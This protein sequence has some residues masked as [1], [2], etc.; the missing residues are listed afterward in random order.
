MN[1]ENFIDVYNNDLDVSNNFGAET[2]VFDDFVDFDDELDSITDHMSL[3][4]LVI[5][6]DFINDDNVNWH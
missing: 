1:G 6:R 5:D 2:D 4:D 3:D